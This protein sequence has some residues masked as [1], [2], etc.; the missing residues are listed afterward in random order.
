MSPPIG[1]PGASRD[2]KREPK[3]GKSLGVAQSTAP[4]PS[5]TDGV[6]TVV[7]FSSMAPTLESRQ[8]HRESGDSA[9]P[10]TLTLIGPCAGPTLGTSETI[11]DVV[12]KTKVALLSAK[13]TPS[14]VARKATDAAGCIGDE[15]LTA[16]S[17]TKRAGVD[18]LPKT[19]ERLRVL[20][21]PEP[22]SRTRDPPDCGPVIGCALD[23]M[24][25]GA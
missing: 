12:V 1:T 24:G 17:E 2:S 16:D 14:L 3:S 22:E 6:A 4:A 11:D 20:R 19:Q 15:Q 13:P 21:K 9:R 7:S 5:H 8:T 18:A 23:T 10:K 25:V